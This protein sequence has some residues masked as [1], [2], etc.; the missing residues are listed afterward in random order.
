MAAGRLS[1]T[2]QVA[3]FLCEMFT[4]LEVVGLTDGS[5]FRLPIS[6]SELGDA[7]GLSV[8]H[9]NRTLQQMRR[10]RLIEWQADT[11][12]ILDRERLRDTAEFDPTYLNLVPIPR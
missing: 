2:G 11:V 4:R 8:V 3:H 9:V 5:S 7:M 10:D 1:S 6:Q 12:R